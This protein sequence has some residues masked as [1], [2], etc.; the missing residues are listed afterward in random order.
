ML[1]DTN[2]S[3]RRAFTNTLKAM[4]T[5]ESFRSNVTIFFLSSISSL[6]VASAWNATIFVQLYA[7]E[8]IY[9]CSKPK[10]R[11]RTKERAEKI[12]QTFCSCLNSF[13]VFIGGEKRLIRQ[14]FFV[15]LK[16]FFSVCGPRNDF[17][18]D[19]R[20]AS[21]WIP[22]RLTDMCFSNADG[23]KIIL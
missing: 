10:S 9:F 6:F 23:E 15:H 12:S 22:E 13:M 7:L 2:S 4:R 14:C 17:I 11:K 16:H 1:N 5:R 20:K 8:K 18:R 19:E 21:R 3:T